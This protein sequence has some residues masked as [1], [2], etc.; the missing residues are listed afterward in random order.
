MLANGNG[1]PKKIAFKHFYKGAT[2]INERAI[3]KCGCMMLRGDGVAVNTTN[4]EYFVKYAAD[5]NYVE[6]I[7]YHRCI[8]MT[9]TFVAKD[10]ENGHVA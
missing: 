3:L 5:G 7:W 6:I 2:K 4:G 10:K 1:I 8:L 9:G